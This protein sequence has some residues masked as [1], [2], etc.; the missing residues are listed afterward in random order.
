MTIYNWKSKF[1]G[2]DV[3]EAKRPR[4]LEEAN[5]KLKK[6][7]A[8]QMRDA[9]ALRELRSKNG[10]ACRQARCGRASAGCH[11]PVGTAS[12]FDRRRGSVARE[13]TMS[14]ERRAQNDTH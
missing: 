6:L 12:L 1:G 3:S 7:L 9:A 2:M 13:L 8:E 11:E 14:V 10:R 5:A 4:V